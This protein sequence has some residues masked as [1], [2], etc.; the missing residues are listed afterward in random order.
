MANRPIC[1]SFRQ[2][3]AYTLSIAVFGRQNGVMEINFF[4]L[5]HSDR[6]KQN[7]KF[8]SRTSNISEPVKMSNMFGDDA[9]PSED[10]VW[11]QL[12]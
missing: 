7:A 10:Q 5:T 8:S 6:E 11:S 4:L 2:F 3:G 9:E 12:L 1:A